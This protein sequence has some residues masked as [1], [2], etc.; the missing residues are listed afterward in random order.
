M[1]ALVYSSGKIPASLLRLTADDD[2]QVPV[3]ALKL[4]FCIGIHLCRIF[5][6]RDTTY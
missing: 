6:F 2:L 3:H 5:G 1:A 4:L